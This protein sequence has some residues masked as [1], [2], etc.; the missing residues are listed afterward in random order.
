MKRFCLLLVFT[1]SLLGA[2]EKINWEKA[3]EVRPGLRLVKLELTEPRLM[4]VSILR[5]DLTLPGLTFTGTG[6]DDAW[7][8]EMP[9]CPGQ[10]IRTKRER[11]TDFLRKARKR[12][13]EMIVAANASPWL[14]WQAPFTHIYG[15]PL[16]LTIADGVIV[17]DNEGTNALFVVWKNGQID[18]TESVAKEQYDQIWLAVSGFG[19]CLKDGQERPDGGYEAALMP[20]MVFGLSQKRHWLYLMTIDGRQ[21]EWS[22]GATGADIKRLMKLAGAWDVIDMDGGGSATL[23]WWDE[24][25]N[26][27]V[28][29]NRHS[30]NG[31]TRSTGMNIGIY[32]KP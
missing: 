20:R 10:I 7:G 22:L 30:A 4:K 25:K 9:D 16:G 26:T 13:L 6:R 21:K 11:T 18:I 17:G 31:Y 15:N 14:P 2:E 24:T 23:C 1:L 27:P 29:V 8:Q 32:L 12:G 19:I 3:T 5:V 28:V